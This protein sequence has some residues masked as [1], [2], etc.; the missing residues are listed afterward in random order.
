MEAMHGVSQPEI[1]ERLRRMGRFTPGP[2]DGGG[3]H[4]HGNGNG[5]GTGDAAPPPGG[6]CAVRRVVRT[7]RQQETDN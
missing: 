4:G 7:P 2:A 5:K 6:G 1:L 3:G